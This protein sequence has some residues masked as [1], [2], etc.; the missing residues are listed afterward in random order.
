M[1]TYHIRNKETGYLD[2]CTPEQ[3]NRVIAAYSQYGTGYTVETLQEYGNSETRSYY[4]GEQIAAQAT[5][6]D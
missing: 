1:T 2:P 6:K 3:Y 5:F 4:N